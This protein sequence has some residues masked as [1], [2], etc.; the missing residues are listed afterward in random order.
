MHLRLRPSRHA[1]ERSE[2]LGVRARAWCHQFELDRELAAGADPTRSPQLQARAH[3]LTSAHFRRELVAQ[4]DGALLKADHQPHWHSASLPV[5]SSRVREARESLQA[6]R[7]ALQGSS[8]VC[9]RG[10]ALAA[11]LLNDPD[12]P[13]YQPRADDTIAHLARAATAALSA[14]EEPS[15]TG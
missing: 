4:L 2:S 3:Q 7:Q 9:V 6:L 12:G 15:R 10:A 8:V 11:C 14:N 13:L 5:Q 1:S